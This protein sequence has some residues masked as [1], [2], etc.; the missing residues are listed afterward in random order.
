MCGMGDKGFSP[1]AQEP[2]EL[3]TPR[4]EMLRAPDITVKKEQTLRHIN[5]SSER[6][7][8]AQ[9]PEK[10]LFGWK[11][12][13]AEKKAL[14]Q[15]LKEQQKREEE[16][17][18]GWHLPS[19]KIID[20]KTGKERVLIAKESRKWKK[21]HPIDTLPDN[22]RR[23]RDHINFQKHFKQR[24][25]RAYEAR[26][27]PLKRE[28]LYYD[29][30]KIPSHSSSNFRRIYRFI[31]D[32]YHVYLER[33]KQH[34]NQRFLWR[35]EYY[36]LKL[37][38]Y[39]KDR[40]QIGARHRLVH[41]FDKPRRNKEWIVAFIINS[42]FIPTDNLKI[43]IAHLVTPGK[44][45]FYIKEKKINEWKLAGFGK[46]FRML[47]KNI[48]K[49]IDKYYLDRHNRRDRTSKR[50]AKKHGYFNNFRRFSTHQQ[51]REY[52]QQFNMYGG[53]RVSEAEIKQHVWKPDRVMEVAKKEKRMKIGCPH[54]RACF[55]RMA[56]LTINLPGLTP[57]QGHFCNEHTLVI[58]KHVF[59][60]LMVIKKRYP[61]KELV[62]HI[63]GVRRNVPFRQL[64]IESIHVDMDLLFIRFD[65][66][67]FKYVPNQNLKS[68]NVE[69]RLWD[70]FNN[71]I[72][73][74]QWQPYNDI[75]TEGITYVDEYN[76]W[77]KN[78]EWMTKSKKLNFNWI[79]SDQ[80]PI[81][82]KFFCGT[83]MQ[84]ESG[85]NYMLFAG[86][87]QG[88][89]FLPFSRNPANIEKYRQ[90]TLSRLFSEEVVH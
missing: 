46:I 42:D 27:Q 13:H 87:D 83:V 58:N 7:S 15:E 54:Y 56:I 25:Q 26:V 62:M 32:R 52:M 9:V 60:D 88:F 38:Q 3:V 55:T 36:T 39:L 14:K 8:S 34:F 10:K 47:E 2:N 18:L 57:N 45:S 5:D 41:Y 69:Y 79:P 21:N 11:K 72:D 1:E 74:M 22:A 30:T 43:R 23:K 51:A 77:S 78:K 59:R 33:M 12:R 49:K 31:R 29:V 65:M 70:A 6:K 76:N 68:F 19:R 71:T 4:A 64:C 28:Q 81:Y 48:I 40:N 53:G 16:E 37:D 75:V 82:K 35:P 50:L 44:I 61:K 66:E 73:I 17:R 85:S 86:N 20:P 84:H 63:P 89:S 67:F 90:V 24:K 80:L